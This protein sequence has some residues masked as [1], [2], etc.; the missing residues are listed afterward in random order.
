MGRGRGNTWTSIRIQD[1]NPLLTRAV[2]KESLFRAIVGRAGQSTQIDQQ[3]H[4]L[5]AIGKGL[6]RQVE[7]E[8]HFAGG[9]FGIV[10]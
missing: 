2:L 5:G 3:R 1:S 4:L 10:A 6:R 8:V 7:V 9:G